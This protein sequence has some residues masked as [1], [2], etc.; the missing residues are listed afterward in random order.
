M[1]TIEPPRQAKRNLRNSTN[2]D[3]NERLA[4]D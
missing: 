1:M 3:N 4:H 2:T